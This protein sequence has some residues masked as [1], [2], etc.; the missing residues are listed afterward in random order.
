MSRITVQNLVKTYGGEDLFAGLSFEVTPG[1]RL[2]V[3]GSNGCGKSTLLRVLAGKV[4][5][6]GGS[7]HLS[8]GAQVGYVAQELAEEELDGTLLGW[9]LSALPSWTEFWQEWEKACDAKDEKKIRQLSE[10]QAEFETAYGYNPDHKARAILSGLGFSEDDYLKSLR[11]LSGGWRER[12]KLA[13]VL[14]QGADVLLLDEP[15]NHLDIEAVEWLEQYLL[16][17]RGALVVVVHDR[18]FLDKVGNHMLFLGGGLATLRKGTFSEYLVWEEETSQQRAREAEKLSAR[19]EHEQGY[20]SRFRVKARKAAQ[21]QSKMKK[22]EKMQDE[23]DKLSKISNPTPMKGL[24]FRLPETKRGDKVPVGAQDLAFH[25]PDGT[26]VWR[27]LNFQLYRGKKVALVAPNGAG[28]STLIKL[29]MGELTPTGGSLITGSNTSIAY[30]SQ[31][32]TD[33]LVTGN[34]VLSELRRLA[35]SSYLE[36][37][38]KSALGLFMLGQEYFDR[39]VGA[40]SGG[41][42]NRLMLASIFMKGANLLI[43]DEPTNHLDIESREGLISALKQYDGTLFFVAHD[44]YLLRSVADEV[45]KLSEEGVDIYPGQYAYFEEKCL[46]LEKLAKEEANAAS[47]SASTSSVCGGEDLD[48]SFE[49]PAEKKRLSKEDKRR[50]AEIRNEVYR[51]VKPRQ[52]EYDTLEEQLDSLMEQIAEVEELMQDPETFASADKAREVNEKYAFLNKESDQIMERMA[53][54]EEEINELN[55]KRDA[56]LDS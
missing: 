39:S 35:D 22:V 33:V 17:F 18:I 28:K 49:K 26:E 13:R 6:D 41:E 51:E 56:L 15:T 2:A 9:V 32:Q 53:V 52:R 8:K 47:A 7:V 11:F 54:L 37:Q 40:L 50:A 55:S 29:I 1:M 44:R 34:T 10:R 20:I 23:L 24:S 12:A 36:E 14:L 16:N 25:Y 21:A 30:F 46:Q 38:L 4:E 48:S 45:W 19:I 3:V 31:H 42:K 43:L 27:N 5:C